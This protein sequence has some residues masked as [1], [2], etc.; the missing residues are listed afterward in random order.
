MKNVDM[1]SCYCMYDTGKEEQGMLL[2]RRALPPRNVRKRK[3][4]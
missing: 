4:N 2:D 3:E 1:E